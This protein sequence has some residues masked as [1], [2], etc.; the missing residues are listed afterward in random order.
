MEDNHGRRRSMALVL[1]SLLSEDTMVVEA[2]KRNQEVMQEIDHFE[3]ER[4]LIEENNKTALK[5]IAIH[6]RH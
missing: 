3:S 4:Q 1:Q 2:K 5:V 6:S